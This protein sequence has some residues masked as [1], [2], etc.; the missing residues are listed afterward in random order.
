VKFGVRCRAA[1]AEGGQIAVLWIVMYRDGSGRPGGSDH[2][3]YRPQSLQ[4]TV[5]RRD[6]VLGKFCDGEA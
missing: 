1:L 4:L 3:H 6:T 5:R 2:H